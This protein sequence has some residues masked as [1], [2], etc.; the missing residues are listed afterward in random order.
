MNV[1]QTTRR[2]IPEDSTLRS[3]QS[4]FY[5]SFLPR[6]HPL[7][8]LIQLPFRRF[9]W[10][11]ALAAICPDYI[12]GFRHYLLSAVCTVRLPQVSSASFQVLTNHSTI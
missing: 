7:A 5:T 2:N 6:T 11:I 3:T 12:N 10:P 4:L 8:L 1:N 9:F